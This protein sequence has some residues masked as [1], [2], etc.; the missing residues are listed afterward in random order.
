MITPPGVML[1]GVRECGTRRIDRGEAAVRRPEEA[2]RHATCV[3][4]R[5]DDHSGRG[6]GTGRGECG[7]R[8]VERGDGRR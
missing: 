4:V 3:D 2:V 6:D 1:V 7:A 8:R 5:S